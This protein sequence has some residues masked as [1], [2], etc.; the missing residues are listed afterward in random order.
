VQI[1][2]CYTPQ[3]GDSSCIFC[4]PPRGKRTNLCPKIRSTQ[5]QGVMPDGTTRFTDSNGDDIFHFMGCSTFSEYTVRLLPI[6]NRTRFA[7]PAKCW[8]GLGFG[9]LSD[10]VYGGRICC[11][12]T[13]PQ[14][15]LL[16]GRRRDLVRQGLRHRAARCVLAAGMRRV[17]RS[18]CC[19]E[20][21]RY[22]GRFDRR[23]VW[24]GCRRPGCHPRRADAGCQADFCN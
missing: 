2:P 7:L 9:G 10:P 1:I 21:L 8:S 15:M 14:C 17:H 24:S 3:C 19:V 16:T 12:G 4:F 5:G 18:W 20:L 11:F 13:D 23:S 6:P 22:R